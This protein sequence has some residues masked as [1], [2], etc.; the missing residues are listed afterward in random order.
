MWDTWC[1]ISL[2]LSKKQGLSL[3]PT[4]E[5]LLPCSLRVTVGLFVSIGLQPLIR[6]SLLGL[7]S[8]CRSRI[9][10]AT[11]V[12]ASAST[13]TWL[14]RCT[15]FLKKSRDLHRGF[16]QNHLKNFSHAKNTAGSEHN[17]PQMVH[18]D[19]VSGHGP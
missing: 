8:V 2:P 12:F 10:G 9:D 5:R 13:P 3:S 19:S 4:R 6:F 16:F 1:Y 17:I 11:G 7:D 15:C 14:S 18:N